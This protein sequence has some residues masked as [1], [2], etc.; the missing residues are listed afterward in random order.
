MGIGLLPVFVAGVATLATPCILPMLPVYLALLGG[1]GLDAVR[2][3]RSR[4]A[5]LAA[6]ALFFL[7]FASVFS[8]LGLAAST[9]GGV[10]AAHRSALLLVGGL[11]IVLF[12]LRFLGVVRLTWLDGTLQLGRLETGV[13]ALNAFAFGVVFAL[14]WTPCVG[15]ILG[16]V[17]TYTAT[18]T[19]RPLEG[20][21]YLFTYS[22]GVGLPLM[23]L[24]ALGDFAVPRLKQVRA[25]L[26]VIERVTGVALV[27][28]GLVLAVPAAAAALGSTRAAPSLGSEAAAPAPRPR[29]IELYS[30]HCPVCERMQPKV[31]RLRRDCVGQRVDI[32]AVDVSDP[33]NAALARQYR[34][35]AVPAFVLVDAEG[36]EQGRLYGERQQDE[37]RAA[38]ASLVSA[39]CAGVAPRDDLEALPVAPACPSSPS[40]ATAPVPSE[41][42]AP[43]A[44][45]G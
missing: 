15:P 1:T 11:V 2:S 27:G 12:G 42:A 41:A 9:L 6:T 31:E 3:A 30:R 25:A 17:L 10:I 23:L 26:P 35:S 37:L 36:R 7:G 40:G 21:L 43:V 39:T 4:F 18:Q 20:A 29:V 33:A 28:L 14:G 19:T 22:L 24:G 32:V 45:G 13:R 44:C 38:A 5:L 34:A 8:L 16:T